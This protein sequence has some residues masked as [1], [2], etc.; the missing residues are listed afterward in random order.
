MRPGR[1]VQGEMG[2]G[3]VELEGTEMGRGPKRAGRREGQ[4][5][6]GQVKILVVRRG[7]NESQI[8]GR[9]GRLRVGKPVGTWAMAGITSRQG[10]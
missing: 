7:R 8:G 9:G 4:A 2:G 3:F 10:K 6:S 5:R 1:G